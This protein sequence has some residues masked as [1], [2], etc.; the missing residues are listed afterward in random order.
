MYRVHTCMEEDG[1]VIDGLVV[2]ARR[3]SGFAQDLDLYAMDS[4]RRVQSARLYVRWTVDGG[5]AYRIGPYSVD[6]DKF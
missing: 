3:R 6:K 2:W 1:F 5:Y 4:G